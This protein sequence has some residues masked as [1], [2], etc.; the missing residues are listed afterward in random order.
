MSNINSSKNP[1]ID[2]S[3]INPN[4][5][6][7]ISFNYEL[8][9]YI[10]TVLIS[11]Q[12]N[13]TEDIIK[14]KTLL[15][16]Q[17]KNSYEIESEVIDLKIERAN[18]SE[19]LDILYK[20][21]KDL[22]SSKNANNQQFNIFQDD[23]SKSK[24][25]IEIYKIKQQKAKDIIKADNNNIINNTNDSYDV[26]NAEKNKNNIK[27]N[28]F[29]NKKLLDDMNKKNEMLKKDIESM[30]LEI[31]NLQK[32]IDSISN[33]IDTKNKENIDNHVFS[34]IEDICNN[35]IKVTKNEMNKIKENMD[36]INKENEINKNKIL[37]IENDI[38]NLNSIL[39]E[40]YSKNFDLI[41]DNIEKIESRISINEQK[42]SEVVTPLI[43][44]DKIKELEKK[45]DDEK[46]ALN[47]EI[48]E[49]KKIS[50]SIMIELKEHLFNYE[51]RD[52]TEIKNIMT[53]LESFSGNINDLNN[54]KK[55]LEEKEKRKLDLDIRKY[56]NP[57]KINKEINDLSKI[58][59]SHK[60]GLNDIKLTIE[61]IRDDE[62]NN[63]ASFKDLKN[64]ENNIFE[65]IE[66]FKN[67]IN[68]NFVDKKNLAKN[69]NYIK[70]Q[71]KSI[72]EENKKSEKNNNWLLAKKPL[73]SHLCASCES[74]IGDLTPN[75]YSTYISNSF[76]PNRNTSADTRKKFLK[77]S[78]GF[79][80]ILQMINKNLKN[81][82]SN[83]KN[84]SKDNE[85][86]NN[87]SIEE[88]NKIKKMINIMKNKNYINNTRNIQGSN[89]CNEGSI[90][91]SLPK[92]LNENKNNYSVVMSSFDNTNKNKKYDEFYEKLKESEEIKKNDEPKITK[93]FRKKEI[94]K[95]IIKEEN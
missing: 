22:N 38:N 29:I 48:N 86:N 80:N 17:Q 91:K 58:L 67:L 44:G 1:M 64:L 76:S 33:N 81:K 47:E 54:Y 8:L 39:N 16:E 83:S 26:I 13:I 46:N 85:E 51:S 6:L 41:K 73:N 55:V 43:L 23:E 31:K 34:M 20:K 42:L 93:I 50:N 36:N 72:I 68:N 65:K 14:L 87:N 95:E 21:K 3:D 89:S 18:T 24:K 5:I 63:K 90:R 79:S 74:Y 28:E 4:K 60:K 45:L 15:F 82:K 27:N 71:T 35:K 62:L 19:E 9:K 70:H 10:L 12:Q 7:E 49:L 66:N 57:E 77:I 52:K 40:T 30:K 32:N 69:L 53:I 92:I 59:E 2:L 94:N 37:N 61:Y 75:N 56:I 11:N 84:N 25:N 88:G 78:G